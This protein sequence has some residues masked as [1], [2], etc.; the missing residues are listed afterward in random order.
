LAL[1]GTEPFGR[2]LIVADAHQVSNNGT[3]KVK[4][5]KKAR[6]KNARSKKG[7]SPDPAE[8]AGEELQTPERN[9]KR[10]GEIDSTTPEPLASRAK[11]AT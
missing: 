3:D 5:G 9:G 4:D 6:D 1:D 2:K 7:D 10:K 11:K 8:P